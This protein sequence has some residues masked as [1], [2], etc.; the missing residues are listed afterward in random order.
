[1]PFVPRVPIARRVV[2][3]SAV[4]SVL[5]VCV[6]LTLVDGSVTGFA[7]AVLGPVVALTMVLV[8]VLGLVASVS[9]RGAVGRVRC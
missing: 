9:R 6:G 3:V 4:A 8:L 2:L 5:E 7:R 1:V